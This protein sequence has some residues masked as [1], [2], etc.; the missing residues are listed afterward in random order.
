MNHLI[1]QQIVKLG[2]EVNLTQSQSLPLALLH[3]NKAKGKGR[4]E[5]F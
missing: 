3:M 1:K 4:V 2:Q 5:S